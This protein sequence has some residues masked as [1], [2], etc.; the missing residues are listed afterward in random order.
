MQGEFD[1]DSLFDL[2][3]Q[4]LAERSV[5]GDGV[6]SDAEAKLPMWEAF[7]LGKTHFEG[8]GYTNVHGASRLRHQL[9]LL[10]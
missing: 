4:T 7:V 8:C 3:Q 5:E 6:C 1:V 9:R 10:C 2:V